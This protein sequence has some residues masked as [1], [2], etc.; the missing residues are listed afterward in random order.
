MDAIKWSCIRLTLLT[1]WR[2]EEAL[3]QVLGGVKK[4]SIAFLGSVQHQ[5]FL[6]TSAMI[7]QLTEVFSAWPHG[8]HLAYLAI[9]CWAFLLRVAS[10]ALELVKG[11]TQCAYAL[12]TG[13]AGALWVHGD[14]LHLRLRKR[15]NRPE[16][17]WL[18]REC[19]CDAVGLRLCPV[20]SLAPWL[21]TLEEGQSLFSLSKGRVV[22]EHRRALALLGVPSAPPFTLKAYRAGRATELAAKGVSLGEIL[23]LGEWKSKAVLAYINEDALDTAEFVQAMDSDDEQ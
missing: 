5:R 9:L 22:S 12:Q 18:S 17:S 8:L 14:K 4:R 3:C 7:A 23:R 21:A 19:E 10:E 1:S 20:H 2:D 13:V 11:G 6:L 16:G 15:V